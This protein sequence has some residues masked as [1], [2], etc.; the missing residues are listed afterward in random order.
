[1]G[2]GKI[3]EAGPGDWRGCVDGRQVIEKPA[4]AVPI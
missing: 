4:E 1:M 3:S 2:M